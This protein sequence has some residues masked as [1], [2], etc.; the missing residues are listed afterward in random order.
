[1]TET[2]RKPIQGRSL[3][4]AARFVRSIGQGLMAVAFTL[5]LHALGWSAAAIG[6]LLAAALAGGV[7]LTAISGPLSDRIGK[8][9]LL[10]G[11][12]L[13]QTVTAAAVFWHP[14]I[15]LLSLASFVGQYGRGA[16]GVAGPFG[17]VEQAWLAALGAQ[18]R[19][20]QAFSVNAAMG[21]LGM[22]VGAM[23][24]ILPSGWGVAA[25]GQFLVVAAG[26]LVCAAILVVVPDPRLPPPPELAVSVVRQ[27]N[28][29]LAKLAFAN[30][31]QGAGIGLS[32]PL[33]AYWVA[34]RFG[35]TPA[36]IGPMMA[37]SF[38]VTAATTFATG[39]IAT[40]FGLVRTVVISRTLGLGMLLALPFSPNFAIAA[41]LYL[42][43]S[44]FNRGTIGAR[45]AFTMNLVR[46]ERRGFAA[47]VNAISTQIPRAAGPILAGVLFDTG[48]FA[49]PFLLAAGLQG[50]YILIFGLGFRGQENS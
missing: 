27:E 18:R 44:L 5:E 24:A 21:F 34:V 1:M 14:S 9:A 4:I 15:A 8:R 45:S 28:R 11:F 2:T 40:R 17:P 7:V 46:P 42:G 19:G 29:Q 48:A 31:L 12:E 35:A 23:L 39:G 22:G 26:G 20:G 13:A 3:L 37:A 49:L 43:R 25:Q 16:N 50:G 33:L 41:A 10:I 36:L 6:T 32:G 38:V 30:A 47:S